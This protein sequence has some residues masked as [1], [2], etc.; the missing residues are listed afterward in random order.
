MKYV[1]KVKNENEIVSKVLNDYPF[2]NKDYAEKIVHMV[3]ENIDFSFEQQSVNVLQYITEDNLKAFS[4]IMQDTLFDRINR[5]RNIDYQDLLTTYRYRSSYIEYNGAKYKDIV[6]NSQ[7]EIRDY[8]LLSKFF[9]SGIYS[10]DAWHKNRDDSRTFIL[11][12]RGSNVSSLLDSDLYTNDIL[13]PHVYD[14]LLKGMPQ[15]TVTQQDM[16]KIN[17]YLYGLMHPT[18]NGG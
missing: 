16:E 6:N 9:I 10:N 8:I 5:N 13:M 2:L 14:T 11:R 15:Y 18:V 7:Y 17:Q 12:T 1:L 3:I 4:K